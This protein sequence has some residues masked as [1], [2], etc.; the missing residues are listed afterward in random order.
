M[1]KW[2][3]DDVQ[4]CGQWLLYDENSSDDNV[5]IRVRGAKDLAQ[6]VADGLNSN[7]TK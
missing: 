6:R 2:I 1:E 7:Q 4:D 3:V 5:C